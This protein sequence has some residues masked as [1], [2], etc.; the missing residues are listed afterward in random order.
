LKLQRAQAEFAAA[1]GVPPDMDLLANVSG[2]RSALA[3][4]DIGK[5]EL[6]YITRLSSERFAGGALWK[7]R[8]AF[9]PRQSSGIDY[10][11]KTDP[12][13]KRVAA[14]AVAKDYVILATQEDLLAGVL[15]LISGQSSA[16]VAGD[17]WFAKSVMEAKSQ[18]ELR[19]VMNLAKLVRSPHFRSYWV[20]Q[21]ITDLQQYAAAIA[22]AGRISGELR[23]DRVLLR[24]TEVAPAWNEAAVGEILRMAPADATIYRAWASPSPQKAFDLIQRKI[25]EPRPEFPIASKLAPVVAVNNGA[26]GDETELETKINEPPL[27]TGGPDVGRELRQLL[28]AVPLDAILEVGASR[29]QSDGVFV[30]TDSGVALLASS[31]WNAGAVR[32]ALTAALERPLTVDRLG[33]QWLD[34]GNGANAYSELDGLQPLALATRGKILAI[35][36][37]KELLTA[38]LAGVGR[39]ASNQGGRYAGAY[40]HAQELPNFVKIMR[41]LDNPLLKQSAQDPPEPPF[42][43][44]NM[45]SFGQALSRIGSESIIVHD[46]GAIVTQNL[47]YRL[48]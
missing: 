48:K 15:S 2:S 46:T 28:D 23:E 1:A 13:S 19:M 45:A 25:L 3:I 16:S 9:E 5:L 21:N 11:L 38:M 33:I 32:A 30:A 47:I 7:T 43:S 29:V 40:R 6:V 12:A 26:V 44:G 24:S 34:R 35:A 41:L 31:D 18:G 42:F 37:R 36:T 4:Y 22:D 39:T 17:Q 20:Q 14:F 8:G 10:Y 27:E